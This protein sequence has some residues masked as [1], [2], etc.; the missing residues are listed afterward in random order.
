MSEKPLLEIVEI[1]EED[2]KKPIKCSSIK[3]FTDKLR[4]VMSALEEFIDQEI[5]INPP[6]KDAFCFK[7]LGELTESFFR[8]F[9]GDPAE[10]KYSKISEQLIFHRLLFYSCVDDDG[11]E[12]TA[13][14]SIGSMI[15]T[16]LEISCIITEKK[17]DK[18][19]K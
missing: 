6:R 15:E 2:V 5:F 13:E 8:T 7:S 14:I 11:R 19:K 3:N 12:K 1:R 4:I 18:D 17:E 16:G 10:Y 9:F